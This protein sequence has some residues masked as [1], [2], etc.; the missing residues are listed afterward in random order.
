[1]RFP[2]AKVSALPIYFYWAILTHGQSD[3]KI[4][5]SIVCA[6]K[7]IA[8]GYD[9]PEIGHRGEVGSPYCADRTVPKAFIHP[10]NKTACKPE[11]VYPESAA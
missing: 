6:T 1:M 8:I 5:D 3:D 11:K 10:K 2:G 7:M 9:V 4:V